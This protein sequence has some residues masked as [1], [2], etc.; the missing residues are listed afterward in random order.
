MKLFNFDNAKTRKGEAFGYSTAILYLAPASLSGE[1]LCKFS[2]KECRELCLNTAGMGV[3][4]KIQDARIRKTKLML[5]QPDIF[6]AQVSHEIEL[7]K[8][9]CERHSRKLGRKIKPCVRLNGTSDIWNTDMETIMH[10][11][12]DVQFYDYSK[13]VK[14]VTSY[15]RGDMP[16]NYYLLYSCSG[17]PQS[18][19][20][21]EWFLAEGVNVAVVFDTKKGKP[22]PL[23]W[24]N[25]PVIDGD[26]HDL[27]FLMSERGLI[28]RGAAHDEPYSEGNVVGLRAKGKARN[29][30]SGSNHF[31]QKGEQS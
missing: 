31:V 28:K 27:R 25:F 7:H 8:K 23:L 10:R 3:F 24:N 11:H 5:E 22:L 13:D 9:L 17:T 14:R 20:H 21:A 4:K 18:I 16:S 12:R 19:A 30:D 6:W 2:T 26:V 29:A 15:R 1:N